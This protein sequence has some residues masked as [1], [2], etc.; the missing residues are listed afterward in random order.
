M[1]TTCRI[2]GYQEAY[3]L[4]TT[5]EY[6]IYCPKCNIRMTDSGRVL[7]TEAS[8]APTQ[9]PSEPNPAS[10]DSGPQT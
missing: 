1:N 4:S 3:L 2:C 10:S 8:P 7:I 9:T 5:N 6:K